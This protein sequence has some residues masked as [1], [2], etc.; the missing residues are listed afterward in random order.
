VSF[1]IDQE[2][3]EKQ[4]STKSQASVSTFRPTRRLQWFRTF[5]ER[6][7]TRCPEGD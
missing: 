6:P 5:Q 7:A 2:A 1:Y 4:C 3:F